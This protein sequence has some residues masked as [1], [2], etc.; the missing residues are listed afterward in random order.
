MNG[1][2]TELIQAIATAAIP[3]CA[4]FLIRFLHRKSDL[5]A[6]QLTNIADKELLAEITDAVSTAVAYVSQTYVDALQK[7][8]TFDKNAQQKALSKALDKAVSLLSKNAQATI[9]EVYGSLD[10][11]LT[12]KIEAEVRMQKQAA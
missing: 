9:R 4:A 11:Y 2:L 10:V 6:A 7:G 12:S 1:F 8:G 5:L 3:V